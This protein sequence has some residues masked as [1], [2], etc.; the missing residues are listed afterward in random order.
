M[1]ASSRRPSPFRRSATERRPRFPERI[2]PPPSSSP[3]S[4]FIAPPG[5]EPSVTGAPARGEESR[6]PDPGVVEE[7][8]AGDPVGFSRP[9]GTIRLTIRFRP[10]P[11]ADGTGPGRP[12]GF[13]LS[14]GRA[15]GFRF[16]RPEPA[17][18][19]GGAAAGNPEGAP[20]GPRPGSGQR[21]G[22]VAEKAAR[23]GSFSR[24]SAQK[25]SSSSSGGTVGAIQ[26]KSTKP[27]RRKAS[28]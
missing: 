10:D 12:L 17:R 18:V 27:A 6:P 24:K 9:G 28:A 26:R 3:R 5:G 7:T 8:A 21:A 22:F 25:P 15:R 23:G 1:C 2:G 4:P 19:P 16:R 14:G 11:A 20:D 13:D